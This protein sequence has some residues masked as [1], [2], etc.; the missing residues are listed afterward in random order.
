MEITFETVMKS[1]TNWNMRR[2]SVIFVEKEE[3]IDI[4]HKYLVV[5][6]NYWINYKNLI[7]VKPVI[8][9]INDIIKCTENCGNIEI[10]KCDKFIS[11]M[12][13]QNIDVFI[14]QEYGK[15]I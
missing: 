5:Q 12:K 6:D 10:Y 7:Q 11:D 14:F 4:V 3:Y 9:H 15:Y 13:A 2:D 8:Y 1:H